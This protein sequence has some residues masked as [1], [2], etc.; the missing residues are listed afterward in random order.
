MNHEQSTL[1]ESNMN[2]VYYIISKYYPTY[3]YDEDI[4]QSGMLGLC[5]AAERFDDTKGKFSTFAGRCIRNEINQEFIR[6]KPEQKTISLETKSSEDTT[7][8]GLLVGS[9][10][11]DYMDES[12]YH[13]LNKDEQKV[14]TMSDLGYSTSEMAHVMNIN[15]S[16][17]QKILRTIRYKWLEFEREG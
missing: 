4:V 7:L 11:V 3:L 17:V 2:L 13:Y 10:D 14:L 16:K 1:V 6:R 9:S 15:V 12:F 5:K 8:E